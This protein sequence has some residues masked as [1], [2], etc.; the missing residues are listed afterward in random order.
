MGTGQSSAARPYRGSAGIV[1]VGTALAMAAGLATNLAIPRLMSTT[2]AGT[3]FIALSASVALPL[4]FRMGVERSIVRLA[5]ENRHERPGTEARFASETLL[6]TLLLMSAAAFVLSVGGWRFLASDVFDSEALATHTAVMTVWITA[7]TGRPILSEYLRGSGRVLAA[8]ILGNAG[9]ALVFASLLPLLVGVEGGIIYWTLTLAAIASCA[10]L[11]A[12][13]VT[14]LFSTGIRNLPHSP[15]KMML[16]PMIATSTTF[17]FASLWSFASNQGDLLIAGAVFAKQD[18]AFYAAAA[19]LSFLL[20]FVSISVVQYLSPIIAT[21]WIRGATDE[22]QQRV[23]RTVTVASIPTLCGGLTLIIASPSV[24]SAVFPAS[25]SSTSTLLAV[26]AVGPLCAMLLG[27]GATV[28]LS[29]SHA[30]L[31]PRITASVSIMQI[32]LM[33]A[34]AA[35]YGPVGLASASTGGTIVLNMA[36]TITCYRKTGVVVL[37]Y[38]RY[39]E[40]SRVLINLS[41]RR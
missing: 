27:P 18:V 41:R 21:L 13:A 15:R 20:N 30:K 3:Y 36:L 8:T 19:K 4:L 26:L 23:R 22:L 7:E 32:G 9:R 14:I 35:L 40:V 12:G 37:P 29:T 34:G 38:L 11:A 25:Y 16:R 17:Y 31:V 1:A 2:A 6:V 5:A 10:V 28:L 39:H 33:F 24:V